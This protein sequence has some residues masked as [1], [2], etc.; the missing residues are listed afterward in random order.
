MHKAI[1][2]SRTKSLEIDEDWQDFH[3]FLKWSLANDFQMGY[4][5]VRKD[6]NEGFYPDNGAWLP[7]EDAVS[8]IGS[9]IVTSFNFQS[10]E[11]Y[12]I[13]YEDRTRTSVSQLRKQSV[14]INE[15]T[16]S[17]GAWEE[18]IGLSC[19]ELLSRVRMGLKDDELLSYKETEEKQNEYT[20]RSI[21][22]DGVTKT[23]KEWAEETGISI[24]TIV[25]R[26]RYG[27]EGND[28]ILQPKG[29]GMSVRNK[30]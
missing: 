14:T 3:N 9:E 15:I 8:L 17:I 18:E 4:V 20:N 10:P 28:L 26:L 12:Y 19:Y 13:N 30:E 21:T 6:E 1:T 22:I 27:W 29:R 23:T 25:S 11:R 2:C 16:K 5:F 24:K 7:Y